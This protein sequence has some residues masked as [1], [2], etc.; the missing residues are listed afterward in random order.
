MPQAQPGQEPRTG[1]PRDVG[2]PEQGGDYVAAVL[3]AGSAGELGASQAAVATY[4]YTAGVSD[5]GC[6]QGAAGGLGLPTDAL[7]SSLFFADDQAATQF[8]HAYAR[9]GGGPLLG[10]AAVT[11]YCLD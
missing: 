8:V 11:A 7:V 3:A 2:S 9:T 5:V 6:L 10:T 1:F 4:G